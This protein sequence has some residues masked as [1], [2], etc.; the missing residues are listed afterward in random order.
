MDISHI[1]DSLNKAQREAVTAP[2]GPLLVLAGA[3]SGKTRVLI[4]RIAWLVQGYGVSPLSILAVTFTNK[5]AKEMRCRIESLLPIPVGSMWIGTFHGLCHRLLRMHYNEAGLPEGFK[6]LDNEDQYLL[7]RRSLKELNLDEAYWSPRQL[8]YM[9]NNHKEEGRRPHHLPDSNNLQQQTLYRVYALYQ[10]FCQRFGL[11]DFAE[12]LLRT[13]ELFKKNQ[14]VRETY[15]QRFQYILIDEFQD[16]NKIQYQ[17]L[18]ILANKHHH[19]FAVGDDDQSIYSWRGARVK[20]ILS[21]DKYFNNATV[22]RLEKNYRSTGNILNAANAVIANNINRMGK[23]LWTDKSAGQLIKV[24]AASNA[25]DEARFVVNQLSEWVE[26]G[27]RRDETAI[28]YRSNAQSRVFE[29]QLLSQSIPYRVYSGLRFFERPEI[30]DA[31][32][33]LKLISNPHSDQAFERI[34]NFPTRGIGKKTLDVIRERSIIKQISMWQSVGEVL[35]DS[36]L[37]QRATLAVNQFQALI[38]QLAQDTY[39]LDLAETTDYVLKGSGLLDHYRKEKGERA[40]SRIDNLEELVN[41]ARNFISDQD[42]ELDELSL[43]LAKTALEAGEDQ[44]EKFEDCVQLMNLHSAKG[45]EFPL[46]FLCGM[47]EGLFPH[48]HSL[49]EQGKMEEERRLC[50]V[51]MTRAMRQLYICYAGI[52]QRYGREHYTQASRFLREVPTELIEEICSARTK[53]PMFRQQTAA[54]DSK[55]IGSLYIGRKVIHKSF[56]EG[57]VVNIEGQGSHA[58]IHVNFVDVGHK[59]LI[60]TYA[61]LKPV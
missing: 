55:S 44:V 32:A 49:A 33:Y 60:Y 9:V 43:F 11:V 3:G 1:F 41:V 19:F 61:N 4:H 18:R 56:G 53:H 10:E 27:N 57:I 58:R 16:T 31:L 8:Q 59:R 46:V 22:I 29:E 24:Y 14:T 28:L 54:A 7:V 17:W 34:V 2:P 12:I 26:Q 15:Q 51:G 50:Y 52:R 25:M 20:N 42:E 5:A 45:L 6:I 47:E 36:I 13:L 48:Y 23:N 35:S 30:K 40:Q 39:E 38:G 21:F 37:P